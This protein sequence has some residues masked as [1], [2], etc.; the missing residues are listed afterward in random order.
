MRKKETVFETIKKDERFSLLAKMLEN[1]GI[2]EA[3]SKERETFTF[4]APTD[5]AFNDLSDEAL[6]FL[7]SADGTEVVAALLS[8]HLVPKSYLYSNDL[9]ERDSLESLSGTRLE[10]TKE[11]NI[12]RLGEAHIL[13]PG[14][15]AL[16][17][18]VFP[19]DKVLPVVIKP[20]A[21]ET[22]AKNAAR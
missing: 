3:M 8:H 19:V 11:G 16:N 22:T 14:I 17:G 6:E 2:G 10:I 20:T 13:T 12:L 1:T 9:R 7:T 5:D 15:S 21:T 18:V 4:F